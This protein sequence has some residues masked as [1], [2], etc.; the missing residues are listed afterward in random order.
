MDEALPLDNG[1]NASRDFI[2]VDDIVRGLIACAEK[3]QPGE[4][5]NL[6]TGRETTILDLATTI[7]RLTGNKTP[8]AIKPARNWDRSGKR[9]ASTEKAAN[10]ARAGFQRRNP[11]RNRAR[12]NRRLDP[13]QSRPDRKLYP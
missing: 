12:Y 3:G 8:P 10:L 9:F 4:V 6:A 13:R 11:N 5:Y 2:F 7:N 1:G